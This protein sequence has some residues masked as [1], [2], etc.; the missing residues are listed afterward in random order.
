M[1]VPISWVAVVSISFFKLIISCSSKLRIERGSTRLFHHSFF[2]NKKQLLQRVLEAWLNHSFLATSIFNVTAKEGMLLNFSSFPRSEFFLAKLC[3]HKESR[4]RGLQVL[5]LISP[6]I[7]GECHKLSC[8][9][10]G[11]V[12]RV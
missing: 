3:G 8:T 7:I 6:S 4:Q 5:C 10:W 11:K 1:R 2:N 9:N 12:G